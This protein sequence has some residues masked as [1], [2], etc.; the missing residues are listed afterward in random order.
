MT[1]FE[2]FDDI[3]TDSQ[4]SQ[5]MRDNLPPNQGG[6]KRKRLSVQMPKGRLS[7]ADIPYDECKAA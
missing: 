5:W 6:R 4:Q 3:E 2:D 7:D 1:E